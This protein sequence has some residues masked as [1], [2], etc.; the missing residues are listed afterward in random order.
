MRWSPWGEFCGSYG[1]R[2]INE[3]N[4]PSAHR[5]LRERQNDKSWLGSLSLKLNRNGPAIPLSFNIS[6]LILIFLLLN[7]IINRMIRCIT[8]GTVQLIHPRLGLVIFR[9]I[10]PPLGYG[11]SKNNSHVSGFQHS[12]NCEN[13]DCLLYRFEVQNI[14][15]FYGA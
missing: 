15:P 10:H 6:A 7:P 1:S 2:K 5:A 4:Q 9:I 14:L 12:L 13:H 3:L 11:N 8:M